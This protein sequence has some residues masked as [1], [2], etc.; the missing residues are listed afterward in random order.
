MDDM[1]AGAAPGMPPEGAAPAAEGGGGYEICIAVGADGSLSVG[2]ERAGAEAAQAMPPGGG[3]P[4]EMMASGE[5]AAYLPA[6]SIKEALT[7][8][9]EIYRADGQ[10][11]DDGG[12]ADFDSGYTNRMPV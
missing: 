8:A 6:G 4:M 10:M 9:L 7:M 12:Q 1:E 3:Q 11:P 5:E 2:A